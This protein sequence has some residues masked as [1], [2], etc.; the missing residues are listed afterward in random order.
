MR[1]MA[2]WRDFNEDHEGSEGFGQNDD[3]LQREV[4]SVSM[5]QPSAQGLGF[6]QP[7]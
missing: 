7:V 5:M 3:S 1:K 4:G 2:Q 6:S